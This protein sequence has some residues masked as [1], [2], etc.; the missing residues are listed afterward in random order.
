MTSIQSQI[1]RWTQVQLVMA[2]GV[3]CAD[4][5]ARLQCL[6]GPGLCRGSIREREKGVKGER[7]KLD[8]IHPGAQSQK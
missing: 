6:T 7:S 5:T 4:P 3:V 1:P 2:V 8:M